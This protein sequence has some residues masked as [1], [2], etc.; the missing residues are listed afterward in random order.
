MFDLTFL[1]RQRY[2]PS[3]KFDACRLFAGSILLFLVSCFSGTIAGLLYSAI[4]I[5]PILSYATVVVPIAVGIPLAWF[6]AKFVRFSRCR[7]PRLAA[8][9]GAVCGFVTF[10][11]AC[12]IE[13]VVATLRDGERTTLLSAAARTDQVQRAI[14][15]RVFGPDIQLPKR[16]FYSRFNFTQSLL[17]MSEIAIFI[18][19]PM[20][21]GRNFA[22]RAFGESIDRWLDR[23]V[24]RTTPGSGDKIIST[25]ESGE[26]LVQTLSSLPNCSTGSNNTISKYSRRLLSRQKGGNV[27][28]TWLVLEV[29]AFPAAN[30]AHEAYLSAT[31]ID[32]KGKKRPLFQQIKLRTHEIATA[33][34]LFLEPSA[35][36]LS[37]EAINL[38]NDDLKVEVETANLYVRWNSKRI[39]KS[40][41]RAS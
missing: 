19:V 4:A 7:N 16:N 18:C 21:S 2:F 15:S 25:L 41:S 27:A 12:E 36:R 34:N 39:R 23:S 38:N 26:F 33:R 5:V 28:G 22:W 31:E 37:R 24:I 6:I 20:Y 9:V 40:A 3:G 29:S 35:D 17:L 30:G 14:F 1:S 13:G 11:S 32:T 10:L 8:L